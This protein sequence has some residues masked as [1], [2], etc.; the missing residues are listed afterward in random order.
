MLFRRRLVQRL[1]RPHHDSN[2]RSAYMVWPVPESRKSPRYFAAFYQKVQRP[3][4]PPRIGETGS[5]Q[6][7]CSE[8]LSTSPE[9]CRKT[10]IFLE[11]SSSRSWWERLSTVSSRTA[12]R[13]NLSQ[14]AL[15]S[16]ERRVGKECG[17]RWTT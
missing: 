5:C 4:F 14:Y 9:S 3:Q 2:G 7:R 10:N 8:K 17:T 11:T 15:R 16:E 13:S 12:S 6:P 1:C